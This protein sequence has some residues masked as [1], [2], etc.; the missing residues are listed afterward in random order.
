[1]NIMTPHDDI[2]PN[3]PEVELNDE[4]SAQLNQFKMKTYKNIYGFLDFCTIPSHKAYGNHISSCEE[5]EC[6]VKW[7]HKS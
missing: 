4:I 1:M 2:D 6:I 3:I 7:V 5:P